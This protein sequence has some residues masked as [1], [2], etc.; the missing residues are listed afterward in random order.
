M[1]YI[2]AGFTKTANDEYNVAVY[3]NG[4]KWWFDKNGNLLKITEEIGDTLLFENGEFH[5]PNGRPAVIRYNRRGNIV[6]QAYYQ[7]GKLHNS[8]GSARSELGFRDE[9]WIN[10]TQCTKEDWLVHVLPIENMKL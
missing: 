7:H 3:P 9:Y 6:Y 2:D 4:Q 1:Q 10:G 5:S 8:L